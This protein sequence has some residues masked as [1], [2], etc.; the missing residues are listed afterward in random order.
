MKKIAAA[1]IAVVLS[2]CAGSDSDISKRL[3]QQFDKG[4]EPIDLAQ[5]GPPSWQRVCVLPPYTTNA[6]A[7][8]VLGF[9]WDAEGN[10]GIASSDGIN[11]L[12]FVRDA[13]VIAYVEHPRSRGD[14][15]VLK[16]RC[17]AQ[18]SAK[19]V[20]RVASSGWVYLVAQNSAF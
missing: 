6:H 4:A 18:A 15:S 9:K 10:T 1:M 16:P 2:A 8:Q 17:L 14:L 5:L 13:K 11:V 20:R 12:A 19:L 3:A 7:E